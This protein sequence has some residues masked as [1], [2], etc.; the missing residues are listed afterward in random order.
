MSASKILEATAAAGGAGADA[1][2]APFD[3]T[4]MAASCCWPPADVDA[5]ELVLLTAMRTSSCDPGDGMVMFA[6]GA[7]MMDAGVPEMAFKADAVAEESS[8]A[9]AGTTSDANSGGS[10]VRTRRFFPE[11]WV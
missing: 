8:A 10:A 1:G 4:T 5:S 3:S 11:T 6:E 2:G 9:E 7:A